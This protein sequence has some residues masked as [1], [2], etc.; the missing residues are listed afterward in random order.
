MLGF[1]FSMVFGHVSSI[2]P[3]VPRA[4]VLYHWSFYLPLALLH[5]SLALRIGGVSRE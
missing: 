3:A 5:L 1:V 4:A 2:F